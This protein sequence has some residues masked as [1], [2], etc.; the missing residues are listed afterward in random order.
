MSDTSRLFLV[1]SVAS[2]QD[3]HEL[4]YVA[5]SAAAGAVGAR[6]EL[7]PGQKEASQKTW[8]YETGSAA[9][10]ASILSAVVVAKVLDGE[11]GP[12]Q[13]RSSMSTSATSLYGK[14]QP[15][16]LANLRAGVQAYFNT[17][18]TIPAQSIGFV[19]A[20][21]GATALLGI[22]VEV[23]A[24]GASASDFI[25]SGAS[26]STYFYDAASILLDSEFPLGAGSAL[27]G[28]SGSVISASVEKVVVADGVVFG[29]IPRPA[30]AV[31]GDLIKIRAYVKR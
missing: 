2:S 30:A 25:A 11:D 10:D 3:F 18:A 19:L 26:S 15:L 29:V 22:E 27:V 16:A 31:A 21:V 17:A 20:G 5:R 4:R 14:L 24:N 12:A 6:A 13:V 9:S 7:I 28:P 23:I 8:I 1:S